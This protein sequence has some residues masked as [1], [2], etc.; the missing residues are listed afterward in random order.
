MIDKQ[1]INLKSNNKWIKRNVII[2]SSGII[3]LESVIDHEDVFIK[4]NEFYISISE[5]RK[6]VRKYDQMRKK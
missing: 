5:L 6:I 3:K 1:I 2:R 4:I